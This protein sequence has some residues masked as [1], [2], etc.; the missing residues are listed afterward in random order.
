MERTRIMHTKQH[1]RKAKELMKELAERNLT[2]VHENYIT[3]L[4]RTQKALNGWFKAIASMQHD[5]F[6]TYAS[7]A[8]VIQWCL[9]GK[10]P[11]DM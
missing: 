10:G 7:V 5:D 8:R 1:Q 9:E 2:V 11:E 6:T 3:S 4:E